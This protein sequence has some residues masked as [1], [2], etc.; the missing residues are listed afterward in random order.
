LAPHPSASPDTVRRLLG[1]C[2]LFH[3]L[4]PSHRNEL[5]ARARGRTYAAGDTIF[6]MGSPGDCLMAVLSGRVRI[7]MTS[8]EGKE[9]VLAILGAGEHF[10]EIALLDGKERTADATALSACTLAVLDRRDVLAFLER[11]PRA[12]LSI[13]EVL[14]TRLRNTDQHIA[15]IALLG[16]PAR[17][18]KAILRLLDAQDA[19]SSAPQIKTSQRALGTMVGASRESINKCLGEWQREGLVKVDG[20]VITVADRK[21]LER[22]AEVG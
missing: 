13:V 21:A 1:E 2:S 7:S 14:C 19:K 3:G 5:M 16:L 17:L 4:D 8:P 10:G 11:H 9:I 12:W 18:A 15:E 20:T 22:V 6:L